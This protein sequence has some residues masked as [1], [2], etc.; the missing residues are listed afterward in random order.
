MSFRVNAVGYITFMSEIKE[1]GN[2]TEV[3]NFNVKSEKENYSKYTSD[4]SKQPQFDSIRCFAF[5]NVAKY[6]L[7]NYKELKKKN[8]SAQPRVEIS[9]YF[10]VK[11]YHIKATNMQFS[12]KN[13]NGEFA[14][15]SNG[16]EEK[17]GIE[18]DDDLYYKASSPELKILEV[19]FI[20]L[21]HTSNAKDN[22]QKPKRQAA[23]QR[24]VDMRDT[25][26]D[27]DKESEIGNTDIADAP[28]I[29]DEI[30]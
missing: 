12:I 9:G 25:D 2:G 7:K 23:K 29:Y 14:K 15:D 4:A 28:S 3:I 6:L 5:S 8:I 30:V 24:I 18:I 20:D 13:P 17:I 26:E 10:E 16:R 11:D 27:E 1:L 21:E 22:T 19:T